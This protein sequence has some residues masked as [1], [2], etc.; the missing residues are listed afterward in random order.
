MLVLKVKVLKVL[1]RIL[2]Y[3]LG[4]Q[5]L[6]IHHSLEGKKTTANLS[7]EPIVNLWKKKVQTQTQVKE[8]SSN[9]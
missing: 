4:N 6:K 3:T 9:F 5:M 8:N 7:S 2:L 1:K